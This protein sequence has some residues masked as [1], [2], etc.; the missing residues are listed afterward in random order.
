MLPIVD[1]P[2][3]QFVVE[4]A[5]SS[6]IDDIIIVTGR[7]KRTI[8]DYFDTSPELENHLAR[9]EKHQQLKQIRAIAAMA[10]IHYIR[11][12]EPTGLG[13]AVLKAEKHVCDEPFAVLLGDDIIRSTVPCV[14]QLAKLFAPHERPLVAVERVKP[15]SIA[16]Y[17]I[18]GGE[19][20]NDS[21]YRVNDVVEKPTRSDAPS[22]L[23]IVGRYVMTPDI[24]DCIKGTSP[25]RGGE[26][27][28]TDA[29]KSLLDIREVHAYLIEG[30][31]YDTGDKLGYLKAVIDFAMEREDLRPAL[32]RYLKERG[33]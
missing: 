20:I 5:L 33:A 31:R 27:Q 26:L 3:I 21:L 15:E 4:E 6:G 22:D 11:Q 29:I 23:G 1:K 7:G 13:D 10:D 16:N 32:A 30:T 14:K 28:L 18:I 9:A 24:F 8:E 25:G 2:V 19:R 17:G 12:K